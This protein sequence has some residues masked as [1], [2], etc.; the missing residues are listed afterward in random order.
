MG[1]VCGTVI[2]RSIEQA[3]RTHEA[4]VLRGYRHEIPFGPMPPLSAKD[5]WITG[6]AVP[7][8]ALAYVVVGRT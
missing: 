6:L 3:V 4:M 5:R 2:I 7:A 1:S 8:L